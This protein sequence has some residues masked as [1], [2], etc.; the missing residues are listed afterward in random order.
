MP[1]HLLLRLKAFFLLSCGLGIAAISGW[2][3]FAY[4]IAAEHRLSDQLAEAVAERNA[5]MTQRDAAIHQIEK[6]RLAQLEATRFSA[7]GASEH[8][9]ALEP[10]KAS[11]DALSAH[12]Q[13]AHLVQ[14]IQQRKDVDFSQTGSI[15]KTKPPKR[16]A[17]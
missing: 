8:S 3:G 11:S 5:I 14:R 1:D 9:P 16:K 2:G 4:K 10:N 6:L 15:R 7:D 13:M 17:H 12:D